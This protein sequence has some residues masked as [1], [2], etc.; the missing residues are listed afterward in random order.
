M[1]WQSRRT[2][3]DV[4]AQENHVEVVQ[5]LV[6]FNVTIDNVTMVCVYVCVFVFM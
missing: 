4:A 3:L 2:P 5:I 6:Q 1:P